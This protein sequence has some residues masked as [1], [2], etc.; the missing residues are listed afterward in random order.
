MQ[1][2]RYFHIFLLSLICLALVAIARIFSHSAHLC[3]VPFQV[4]WQE[5][6]VELLESVWVPFPLLGLLELCQLA[7]LQIDSSA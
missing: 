7:Y 5:Y 6:L 4:F 1:V 2:S 3:S